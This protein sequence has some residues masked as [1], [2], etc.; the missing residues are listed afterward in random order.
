M[1]DK[2]NPAK[3]VSDRDKTKNKHYEQTLSYYLYGI[4]VETLYSCLS[5]FDTYLKSNYRTK[6]YIY[7]LF[8]FN[9]CKYFQV[10]AKKKQPGRI[11]FNLIPNILY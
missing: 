8:I 2:K 7:T 11:A 4:K 3:T 6:I 1:L 9:L 5:N 10:K